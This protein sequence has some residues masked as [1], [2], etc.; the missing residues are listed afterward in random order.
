M[1]EYLN[2]SGIKAN[3]YHAG[4]I[5]QDRNQKQDDWMKNKVRVMV[6][7]NAFGMGIDKPDVR[8]VVHI[9]TPES[10]EAYYQEA[11]RAGR[12]EKASFA[13]L[14]HNKAD[15]ENLASIE[16]NQ[17]P[18]VEVIKTVYHA[19]GNFL[20]IAIGSGKGISYEFDLIR[21]ATTY[22]L[23][24]I[25]INNCLKIL[26]EEGYITL[27]DGFYMPSRLK[28]NVS[29]E[30]I[31]KLQVEQPRLELLVKTILRSYGGLFDDYVRINERKLPFV[32]N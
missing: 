26:E 24:I 5:Q 31:Y 19:L 18:D 30:E 1:S 16:K 29:N 21:M 2:A 20:N 8:V 22:N 27:S 10:L 3:Y 4:L 9:D 7:T 13:V 23:N 11:G 25:A 17:F 15:K 12:D 32:Q 28:L 6:S 14:F